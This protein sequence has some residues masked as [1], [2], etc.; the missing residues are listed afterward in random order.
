MPVINFFRARLTADLGPA[1]LTLSLNTTEG[2]VA[3]FYLVIDADFPERREVVY[4]SAAGV[5]TPASVVLENA[6]GRFQ[7]GSTSDTGVIHAAGARVIMAPLAQDFDIWKTDLLGGIATTD[8]LKIADGTPALPSLA[9]SADPDTG[10]H[11]PG[12]NQLALVTGGARRVVVTDTDLSPHTTNAVDLGT[13]AARW[14]DIRFQGKPFQQGREV[15]TRQL[16]A[17]YTAPTDIATFSFT[18]IPQTFKSLYID[19][20]GRATVQQTTTAMY[21]VTMRINNG[22]ASEH[23]S[24]TS[25]TTAFTTGDGYIGRISQS[26]DASNNYRHWSYGYTEIVNY[27]GTGGKVVWDGSCAGSFYGGTYQGFVQDAGGYWNT[28]IGDAPAVTSLVFSTTGTLFAAGFRMRLWGV[29]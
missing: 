10:L 27:R 3:P 16:I 23:R 26:F 28:T 6:S 4:C 5:V 20:E 11:R 9:F 15:N 8:G 2:L 18:D 24:G 17:E 22:A 19:W 12:A 25:E 21:Y 1:D 7:A 14:K 29:S 13:P